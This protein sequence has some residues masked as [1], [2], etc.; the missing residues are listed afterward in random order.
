MSVLLIMAGSALAQDIAPAQKQAPPTAAKDTSQ[1]LQDS[2][3]GTRQTGERAVESGTPDEARRELS[4][5]QMSEERA[6]RAVMRAERKILM[7]KAKIKRMRQIAEEKGDEDMLRKLDELD[8]KLTELH[9]K[10]EQKLR[11]RI[12]PEQFAQMKA[13]MKERMK[14]RQD[15]MKKR[16]EAEGSDARERAERNR[17]EGREAPNREGREAP[18]REGRSRGDREREQGDRRRNRDRERDETPDDGGGR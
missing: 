8:R 15:A 18:D 10:R 13:K 14:R 16:R 6:L 17:P 11:E 5:G 7:Q 3:P 9:S 12:G 1:T 4:K 2:A